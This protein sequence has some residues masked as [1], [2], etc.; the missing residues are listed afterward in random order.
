[1]EVSDITATD[2][3]DEII[4]PNIF[5]EYREQVTKRMKDDQY[6]LILSIYV[7]SIFQD[8]ESFRKTEVALVEDDI[9]LVLDEYNSSFIA[10][11][12]EPGICTFIDLSEAL[13]NIF[14]PEYEASSNVIVFEL[15][16]ITM[17]IKLVVRSGIRAIRFDKKSFSNTILGFIPHLDYKHYTEDISRKTKKT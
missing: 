13:F 16:D 14:Q 12:L 7:S 2:L 15:D 6:M 8:F 9:R 1:M 4:A 17:K 3:R 5:K 10:Y 11:E